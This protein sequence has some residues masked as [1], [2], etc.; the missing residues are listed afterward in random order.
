MGKEHN[1]REAVTMRKVLI[2]VEGQTEETFVKNIIQPYFNKSQLFCVPKLAVT[3][4]VKDGPDFKGG[5]TS[6]D[7]VKGDI[8]RLLQDSSA[9]CVTTMIDYYGFASLIDY[10]GKLSGTCYDK[11]SQVEEYFKTDINNSRFMPYLQ[12]HEFE[13]L[14]FSSPEEIASVLIDTKKADQLNE[15]SAQFPSP[16]HINDNPQTA[17]SKR[18]IKLFPYYNKPSHG[19]LIAK[20]IGFDAIRK[21][22]CHFDAWLKKLEAL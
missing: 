13:G 6:Y 20:R 12:I 21:K 16:E 9:V 8:L 14:L 2:L 1:R 22:C 17:P 3:R 10:P 15:I 4:R 11:A 19:L 18:I 5:I 7:K